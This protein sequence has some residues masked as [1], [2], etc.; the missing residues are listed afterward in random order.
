MGKLSDLFT[1]VRKAR[2]GKGIGFVGKSTPSLKPRAAALFVELSGTDAGNAEAVVKAGV[3]GLILPWPADLAA[4]EKAVDTAR[5]A[6]EEVVC[7]LRLTDNWDRLERK[8]FE[9]FK[10][11]ITTSTKFC[12][13][14]IGLEVCGLKVDLIANLE[15]LMFSLPGCWVCDHPLT[16]E[17]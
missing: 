10:G 15:A 11:T 5:A 2:G 7:G 6:G 9:D 16:S 13:G 3:D 12:R 14:L 1:Q 8:D 17:F 4:V